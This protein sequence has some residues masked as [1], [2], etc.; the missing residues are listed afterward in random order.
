[1]ACSTTSHSHRCAILL[2]LLACVAAAGCNRDR[3]AG[4]SPSSRPAGARR[5]VALGRLEP[6]GGIVSISALPGERLK[7]FAP[8]VDVGANVLAGAELGWVSSFDLRQTQLEAVDTKLDIAQRQRQHERAV[9]EVQVKQAMAGKAQA[10]AKRDEVEAQRRKLEN[11]AEA[12]AIAV[13]DYQRLEQLQSSDPELV[14]DHQLRRQ[15][16]LS[17]SAQNEYEATAAAFPPTLSAAEKAV[18]AAAANIELAEQ[19]LQ[20]AEEVDQT[21]SVQMER[22]VAEESLDQSVLRAPQVEGGSTEFTVLQILM[23]P[24]EIVTQLPV[25]E[26]ADMS[27]MVTIA[28]VYEADA[29]E[30]LPGQKAVIRSPAFAGQFADDANGGGGMKGKVTRVGAMVASPG[31]TNRN[32]LA[33]SDRSVVEVEIEIT[34]PRAIAEAS[35]RIG[36]Q[37]TVEFDEKS[38]PPAVSEKKADESRPVAATQ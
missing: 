23:Q 7:G 37:V 34:D 32:P 29:K 19:N 20:L 13:E 27:R 36:L 11:L 38:A 2:G 31:L 22:K 4:D 25:L 35:Q 28:E 17:D 14:T 21:L 16:N 24:G 3:G 15:R 1:M 12:A 33:P 9:A 6:A 30:I 8:G 18:E 10:E 26:I 5:V